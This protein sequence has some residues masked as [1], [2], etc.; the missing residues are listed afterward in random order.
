MFILRIVWLEEGSIT[1]DAN[2][3]CALV[4]LNVDYLTTYLVT[5]LSSSGRAA[6]E[7]LTL[8]VFIE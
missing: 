2:T 8:V 3:E 4:R 7:F 5:E 6:Q 1:I